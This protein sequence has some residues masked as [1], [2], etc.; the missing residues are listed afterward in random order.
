MLK[1]AFVAARDR[2][3]LATI[4]G[5]LLAYGFDKVVDRMGLRSIARIVAWRTPHVDVTRLT[6]PQRVRR[7]IEAL[8]PTFVKLGQILAAR[9]DMLTPQWTEELTKLHAGVAPLPWETMR[10]LIEAELGGPPAEIFAE[11]DTTPIA[12]ASIA[13]VY[14]AR[15]HTGEDVVVKVLRPGLHKII[16]ADLR[17]LSARDAHR[18]A[19]SGRKWLVTD[20]RNRCDIWRRRSPGSSTSPTKAATASCSPRSSRAA[21]ISCFPKSIGNGRRSALL[22]QEFIHGIFLTHQEKLLDAAGLDR[23]AASKARHRSVSPDGA[24]RG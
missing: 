24:R 20:H 5:V 14:R 18:R 2:R 6:R 17:L 10:P 7:A 9:P 21:M 19:A 8:G 3:R 4:V 23:V 16:E 12:S 13:Q 15:L 22:V 11:F 1:T